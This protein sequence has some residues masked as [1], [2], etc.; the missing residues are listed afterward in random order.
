MTIETVLVSGSVITKGTMGILISLG[1][2]NYVSV[3][4]ATYFYNIVAV[5]LILFIAAMSG[6]RSES[7]FCVIVPVFAGIFEWFGWLTVTDATTH[8][9]SVTATRGL[10]LTTVVM[11]VLGIMLYMND[12]NRTNYGV[13]GPGAKWLNVAFF[14]VFFNVGLTLVSGFS[15]FPLEGT[16]PIPG[17]CA[18]GYTCDAYNNV[19]FSSTANSIKDSGGLL[20]GVASVLSGF[21]TI[22]IT[23]FIVIANIATGIVAFPIVLNSVINGIYPGIVTE[24]LYL[25]FLSGLEVVILTIYALGIFETTFKPSPGT[26]SL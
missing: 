9:T 2:E 4:M 18:V 20:S 7:A 25:I 3:S 16:Q 21:S 15:V 26:G 12:Q 5:G 24:P 14:L 13:S 6:Q 19:D 1:F 10:F 11:A 8:M 23:A 22:A 17:T